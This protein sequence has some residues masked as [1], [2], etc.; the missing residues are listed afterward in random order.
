[1]ENQAQVASGIKNQQLD[2]KNL[3]VQLGQF[4]GE[5][6]TRSQEGLPSDTDLYLEKVNMVSI[7]NGL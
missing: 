3:E 6:N 7:H 2:T 5:Q 4:V 1:M